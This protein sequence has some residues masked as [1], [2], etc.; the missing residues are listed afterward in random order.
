M[1]RILSLFLVVLLIFA[2]AAGC[3]PNVDQDNG[4][5]N[6]Q[7]AGDT[8]LPTTPQNVKD[9]TYEGTSDKDE[10]GN[11]GKVK[12]TVKDGKFTEVEYVEYTSD[13][14][15]KSQENGYTYEPALESFEE[16]P[17]RLLEEQDVEKVDDYTEATGTSEKFRIAAKNALQKGIE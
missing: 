9:G 2:V 7:N 5:K 11:Y 17:K 1:K 16:L 13:D 15:P 3:A 12:I 6:G 8:D 14:K 10:R 4:Q